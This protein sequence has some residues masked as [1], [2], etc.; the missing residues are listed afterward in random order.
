MVIAKLGRALGKAGS[1]RNTADGGLFVHA[2]SSS[3]SLAHPGA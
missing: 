2:S 3:L 1:R